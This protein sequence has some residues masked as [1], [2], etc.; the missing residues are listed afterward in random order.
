MFWLKKFI[1]SVIMPLPFLLLIGLIGYL[2]LL[3]GRLRAAKL[4]IGVS[5]CG[6]LLLSM[7]MVSDK[8]VASYEELTPAIDPAKLPEFDAIVVLGGSKVKQ[9]GQSPISQLSA[10]TLQRTAEGVRL[11]NLRPDSQVIFTGDVKNGDVFTMADANAEAAI[12][13]GVPDEQIIRLPWAFDTRAEARLVKEYLGDR[14]FLLV[15]SATHLP[16]AMKEFQAVGLDPT[17]APANHIGRPGGYRML[18][19]GLMPAARFLTK[20]EILMHE[21]IGRV[22]QWLTLPDNQAEASA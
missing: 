21:I 12:A 18:W 19:H 13:L 4:L 14:P 10:N 17:P 16:R 2:L 1:G 3:T 20:A 15:S 8:L 11:W 7:P 6:L 22:W 5:L 9:P